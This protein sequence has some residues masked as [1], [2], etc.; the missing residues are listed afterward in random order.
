[1]ASSALESL[2]IKHGEL[3]EIPLP[4]EH[5]LNCLNIKYGVDVTKDDVL[6]VL[7]RPHAKLICNGEPGIMTTDSV[8]KFVNDAIEKLDID[9]DDL[10]K[11]GVV[12]NYSPDYSDDTNKLAGISFLRNII[13]NLDKLKHE[14]R[15]RRN[16]G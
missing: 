2:R 15:K 16:F 6:G 14:H 10:V 5:I 13:F 3:F 4:G 7:L 12:L 8:A 1:M 11:I 9:R